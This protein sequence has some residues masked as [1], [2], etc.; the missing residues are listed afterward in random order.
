MTDKS[1][2]TGASVCCGAKLGWSAGRGQRVDNA[3][4]AA[5]AVADSRKTFRRL[6]PKRARCERVPATLTPVD[7]HRQQSTDLP[8]RAEICVLRPFA[9]ACVRVLCRAFAR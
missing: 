1:R 7:Q 5:A 4:V 2:K 9:S 6:R 8:W 3:A